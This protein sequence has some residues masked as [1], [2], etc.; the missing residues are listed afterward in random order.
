V[1]KLAPPS[2]D[3]LLGGVKIHHNPEGEKLMANG[4]PTASSE[5]QPGFMP[6]PTATIGP[7]PPNPPQ[8]P[9]PGADRVQVVPNVPP[10]S[11]PPQP[12]RG[13]AW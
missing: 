13:R 10:M 5:R 1:R 2:T 6:A 4:N 9:I 11:T 3:A 12:P 7:T 8:A